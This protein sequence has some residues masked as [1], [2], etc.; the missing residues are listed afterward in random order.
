[1][2]RFLGSFSLQ[3][4]DLKLVFLFAG[5]LSVAMAQPINPGARGFLGVRVI[6]PTDGR[7]GALIDQVAPGSPAE[8]AGLK[9]GD[10]LIAING[11]SIDRATT[12][13]R[14]VS[15]MAP[16]ETAHLSV[17]RAG[18]HRLMIAAV[19]GSPGGHSAQ[20]PTPQS[21]TPPRATAPSATAIP[22]GAPAKPLAIQ[23]Y[24]RITDPWEK[25]FTIEVPAGWRAE[26]GL[27]RHAALQIRP[28]VRALS[29]DKMVYLMIGEPSIPGYVPPSEMLYRI[30]KPE[31]H[32]YDSGLGGPIMVLRYLSGVEFAKRYGQVAIGTLCPGLQFVSERDRPDLA[33]KAQMDWP[34]VIPSMFAGGEAIFTCIH[35]KQQMEARMEVATMITRDRVG[36]GV[37]L[38][39]AAIAPKGQIE[40]AQSVLDHIVASIAWSPAWQQM[41]NNISRAAAEEI[42]RRAQQSLR[43]NAAY[44]QELNSSDSSFES[45]DEIVSGYSHYHD[46][47]TGQDYMLSNTNPYKWKDNWTGRIFST[48][49]NSPPPFA[50]NVQPL[51]RTSQ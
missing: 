42:N 48:P 1:M 7:A 27:V 38:L 36:W 51:A 13:T 37:M 47:S 17:I 8:N 33:R 20:Q 6:D 43:Q 9:P 3:P 40:Q 41:Q 50:Y 19:I 18:G 5:L 14:I 4:V 31:G 34:T 12:L 10:L 24:T 35:G 39:Q 25:S 21:A 26:A 11:K 30:G 44:I 49:T 46:A 45:M 2:S 32:V 28:Y 22:S 29:P 16:N 23:G 15:S